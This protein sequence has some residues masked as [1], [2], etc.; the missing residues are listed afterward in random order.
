[1]HLP[2]PGVLVRIARQVTNEG[3]VELKR[4]TERD[5]GHGLSLY[6]AG[7]LR[8]Q[9]EGP[10]P[11]GAGPAT[12][13]VRRAH[14]GVSGNMAVTPPLY[15]KPMNRYVATS[16]A[17]ALWICTGALPAQAHH[18]YG[19]FFDLCTFVTIEGRVERVD[20]KDPHVMIHLTLDDGTMHR[21]EWTDLRWLSNRGITADV[22]RIG[23]RV[24]IT[25][26]PW[27]DRALMDPATRAL[28]SD[29][30]PKVISALTRIRRTDNSWS[31][32]RDRTGP[33]ADCARK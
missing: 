26:S 10:A 30:P 20:W 28:V 9:R 22:L 5:G 29:P 13:D 17:A 32:M 18:A 25:G 4:T 33:A 27:R 14:G 3:V 2:G 1:M 6:G 19:L 24:A 15:R 23:D 16:L 31:W 7:H 21:A 8:I 12:P 11:G